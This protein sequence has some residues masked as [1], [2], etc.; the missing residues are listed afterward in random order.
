MSTL[1][2][3]YDRAMTEFDARVTQ[4]GAAQWGEPTPCSEWDVRALVAHLVDESRWVPYLL[5]GGSPDAAG[6]R[7]AGDPLGDDPKA[8]WREHSAAARAALGADGALDHSVVVSAGEISA[9]D[10]LWQ[11]T[12]DLT[13]HAW[14]LARGIGAD[15]RLDAEL[16]R[17]V[18]AGSEKDAESLSHS[19]LF[20]PPLH[21][22]G[23]ADLQARMLG[24]FGRRA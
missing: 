12:I 23:H 16:V 14:D 5:G 17:R 11:L 24:L 6:D 2:E 18:H 8:A 9:R 3:Q 21:I 13:V 10:Y 7:F 1:L 4:I 15:D 22:P 20:D 19:G